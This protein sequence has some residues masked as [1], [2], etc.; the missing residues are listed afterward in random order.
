MAQKQIFRDGKRLGFL[1]WGTPGYRLGAAR[2][3]DL[4][5]T[6]Q[7]TSSN[8]INISS[9]GTAQIP[10]IPNLFRNNTV[11]ILPETTLGA[12]FI[13]SRPITWCIDAD[14]SNSQIDNGQ[15]SVIGSEGDQ[16]VLTA[17]VDGVEVEY[18][19]C[20]IEEKENVQLDP[21]TINVKPFSGHGQHGMCE[22]L[23]NTRQRFQRNYGTDLQAVELRIGEKTHDPE[24]R[25]LTAWNRTMQF[26]SQFIIHLSNFP[27]NSEEGGEVKWYTGNQVF[28]AKVT[29]DYTRLQL[30]SLAFTG[31]FTPH[32]IALSDLYLGDKSEKIASLDL[33]LGNDI[34]HGWPIS[35]RITT[36]TA[37]KLA[38]NIDEK[39]ISLPIKREKI[40]EWFDSPSDNKYHRLIII[41]PCIT[42]KEVSGLTTHAQI[43]L[44][45]PKAPSLGLRGAK[46]VEWTKFLLR[47]QADY[48]TIQQQHDIEDMFIEE[49]W[50]KEISSEKLLSI[51]RNNIYRNI[52]RQYE[53]FHLN[54]TEKVTELLNEHCIYNE[55]SISVQFKPGKVLHEIYG[56]IKNID[57]K[58]TELQILYPRQKFTLVFDGTA[59]AM[60][61]NSATSYSVE[62]D[63]TPVLDSDGRIYKKENVDFDYNKLDEAFAYRISSRQ[64]TAPQKS[65]VYYLYVPSNGEHYLLEIEVHC[66]T[67]EVIK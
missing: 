56:G 44:V 10:P 66:F 1:P 46:S 50:V 17:V 20:Q 5:P 51:N 8:Q 57:L 58:S 7:T 24:S 49:G 63:K 30:E 48:N 65:G 60:K 55:K 9:T 38:E 19:N 54:N 34:H 27:L 15:L 29:F 22:L 45:I 28:I 11:F 3:T 37:S 43:N 52:C 33:D 25:N 67:E 42:G 26:G 40:Q 2:W 32:E 13:I 14:D 35:L 16:F 39:Q 4:S 36:P 62:Y 59:I 61:T 64:F 23:C 12:H 6:D 31:H 18:F 41:T 21:I 53:N 47:T